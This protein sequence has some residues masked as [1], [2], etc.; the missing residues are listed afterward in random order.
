MT[1]EVGDRAPKFALLDETGAKVSLSDFAGKSLVIYFYPKAF[2]PGCTT[3]ACDLRDSHDRFIAA[4]HAVVGVSPDRVEKLSRFREEYELP[5]SVLSD[6][7]HKV[8]AAYGA[9]GM[10]KNYGKE[11]EGIIRSTFLIDGKGVIT[12]AWRN[13]KAAGHADRLL[14][15]I[16]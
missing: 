2:T 8:A 6:P 14:R 15:E 10:K 4:G 16:A 11:Y 3:Q 13:V 5:F 9:W 12:T 7:D 1:A